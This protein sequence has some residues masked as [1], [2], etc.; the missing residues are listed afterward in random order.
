MPFVLSLFGFRRI[1]ILGEILNPALIFLYM[2]DAI[3]TLA[4][5][6]LVPLFAVM[7]LRTNGSLELAGVLWSV[8]FIAATIVAG[9][10]T[11]LP[12]RKGRS[13]FFLHCSYFIRIIVWG[14]LSLYRVIPFL[15]VTQCLIGVASGLANPAFNTLVSEHLN[16]HKHTSN[17]AII[18]FVSQIMVA[19]ASATSG[20]LVLRFGFSGIFVVMAILEFFSLAVIRIGHHRRAL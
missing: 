2:A 8:Q 15:F 12:D 10:L 13:T 19:L 14:T 6:L 17:W 3:N 18:H 20:F 4:S 7:I 5:N 1:R 11:Q 16:A 9:I